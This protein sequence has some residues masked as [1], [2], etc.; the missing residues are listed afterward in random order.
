MP[1]REWK[2]RVEDILDAIAKVRRY[3]ENMTIDALMADEKTADAVMRNITI[4]GEASN[5]V[6]AVA[7]QSGDGLL[8]VY[9]AKPPYPDRATLDQIALRIRAG[10]TAE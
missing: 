3:T 1:P 7:R 5:H 8:R 9:P 10:F 4:I 2:L 6:P